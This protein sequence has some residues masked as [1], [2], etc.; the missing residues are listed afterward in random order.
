MI[1]KDLYTLRIVTPEDDAAAIAGLIRR[2]FATVA[3]Q[4][5]LTAKNCPMHP[6]FTTRASFEAFLSAGNQCFCLA[7]VQNAFGLARVQNF[8]PLLIGFAALVP[9]EK[10]IMELTRLCV[11]PEQRH[12]GHGTRLLD[13]AINTARQSGAGK[14]IIG[15]IN[16]HAALK[17]WYL[18]YGFRELKKKSYAHLPF[19]VCE[20]EYIL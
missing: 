5:G 15:I 12:S 7:R 20:M 16:E 10:G 9:V 1:E 11:A 17:N 4:F 8:E 19:V 14:V 6:A 13:T 3:E 18:A 2:S